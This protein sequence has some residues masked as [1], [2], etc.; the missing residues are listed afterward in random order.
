[1]VGRLAKTSKYWQNFRA[2]LAGSDT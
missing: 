2:N 1:L